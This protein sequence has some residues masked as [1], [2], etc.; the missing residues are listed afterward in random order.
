M[1]MYKRILVIPRS[2][3]FILTILHTYHDFIFKGHFGFLQTYKKLTG[4]LYWKRMKHGIKKYYEKCC[5]CQHNK[6]LALSP[7]GLLLSL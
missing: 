3:T 5:V 7:A 2:S 1:L 4:E 6:A